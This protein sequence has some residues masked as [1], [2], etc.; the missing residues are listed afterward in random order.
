MRYSVTKVPVERIQLGTP[1]R[2]QSYLK[3][4]I[5]VLQGF[6]SVDAARFIGQIKDGFFLNPETPRRGQPTPNEDTVEFIQECEKNLDTA[7]RKLFRELDKTS[8]VDCVTLA[9]LF[10]QSDP[11]ADTVTAPA[12]SFSYEI[13]LIASC[14]SSI[15]KT[16]K[17]RE[18]RR[19]RS[20]RN[21]LQQAR[22]IRI[23]SQYLNIS[24]KLLGQPKKYEDLENQRKFQDILVEEWVS[25]RGAFNTRYDWAYSKRLASR[26]SDRGFPHPDL[27]IIFTGLNNTISRWSRVVSDF[28]K[29]VSGFAEIGCLLRQHTLL[30][31]RDSGKLSRRL[32]LLISQAS[33]RLVLRREEMFSG[34]PEEKLDQVFEW[35]RLLS[36]KP[37]TIGKN[38]SC[39]R[40]FD[41][42]LRKN[43]LIETTTGYLITLTHILSTD[44]SIV[45]EK[46]LSAE[47]GVQYYRARGEEVESSA[48]S[49]LAGVLEGAQVVHGGKYHGE[50]K[51]E[52]IEVDGVVLCPRP[53]PPQHSDHP[54]HVRLLA[55]SSW[56][57]GWSR[58][59]VRGTA[60]RP[61]PRPRPRPPRHPDHPR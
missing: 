55:R 38:F 50:R 18:R 1:M 21:A 53:G 13:E 33:N 9:V 59:S 8:L 48:I 29:S 37:E 20:A 16:G 45:L 52:L 34:V 15:E 14:C 49:M 32:C 46:V 3:D 7:I 10:G 17:I 35:T 6:S 61:H 43:P 36:V 19:K 24:N 57:P 51:G 5:S 28:Q 60:D 44:I 58:R 27:D 12:N 2:D 25:V 39:R 23:I 22:I 4:C 42:P 54:A 30:D 47:P 26:L 41:S 40:A 11:R 31:R 56:G